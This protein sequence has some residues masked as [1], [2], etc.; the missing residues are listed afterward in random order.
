MPLNQALFADWAPRLL[1]VL[2]IVTALLFIQHGTAKLFGIPHIAY[3]DNLQLLS[4]M[5]F[6]GVL[7]VM[8]G[9]LVLIGWFTRPAAFILS[10]QMA[11]AYFMGHAPQ[12]LLPILNQGEPA[13]LF[14]FVFLYLAAAGAGPWS[15]DAIQQRGEPPLAHRRSIA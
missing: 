11:F 15:V 3:F 9:L 12:G 13:V 2:R 7:E 4:L 10:G 8:G 1:S 6:A 5:G 14:C